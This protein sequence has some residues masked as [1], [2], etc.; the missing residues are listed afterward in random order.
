MSEKKKLLGLPI[1]ELKSDGQWAN[2]KANEQELKRLEAEIEA[3]ENDFALVGFFK[4]RRKK[5][6]FL[7]REQEQ[8]ENLDLFLRKNHKPYKA[9]AEENLQLLVEKKIKFRVKPSRFA[10]SGEY[11]NHF[12]GRVASSGRSQVK[13]IEIRGSGAFMEP[14]VYPAELS[15]KIDHWGNIRLKTERLSRGLKAM[16]PKSYLGDIDENGKIKLKLD[17][18]DW[19]LSYMGWRTIHSLEGLHFSGNK[20]GGRTFSDNKDK[21]YSALQELKKELLSAQ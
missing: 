5:R 16:L 3:I 6:D 17:K 18:T 2:L 4:I 15:G 14:S 21:M 9:I 1:S 13:T 11:A 19:L 20:K 10:L 7:G 12:F 8:F